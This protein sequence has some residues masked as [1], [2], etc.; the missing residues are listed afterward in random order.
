MLFTAGGLEYELVLTDSCATLIRRKAIIQSAYN[1]GVFQ[2]D[3]WVFY[4]DMSPGKVERVT[5]DTYLKFYY[6]CTG[7]DY[8]NWTM[9]SSDKIIP[10]DN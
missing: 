5:L 9:Y 4:R 1:R 6:N 10:A 3:Q 2:N 7:Y 8:S